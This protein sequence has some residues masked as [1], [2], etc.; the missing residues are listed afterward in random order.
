MPQSVY[1]SWTVE[2]HWR[3][4]GALHPGVAFV[5]DVVAARRLT[6]SGKSIPDSSLEGP[7]GVFAVFEDKTLAAWLE[8]LQQHRRATNEAQ[9]VDALRAI[10]TAPAARDATSVAAEAHGYRRTFHPG[11]AVTGRGRQPGLFATWAYTAVPIDPKFGLRSFCGDST[12]VVCVVAG[13]TMPPVVGGAC[14]KGCQ[15]LP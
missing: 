5:A 11:A 9:T 12:G 2:F 1:A 15:P 3:E 10:R 14:P 8:D 4:K 7:W 13:A 6:S